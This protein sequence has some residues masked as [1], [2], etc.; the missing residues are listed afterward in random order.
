MDRAARSGTATA[1]RWPVWI[2]PVGFGVA[3]AVTALLVT[4]AGVVAGLA[5]TE[6]PGDE[7]SVTIVGTLLQD[8]AL[9]ASAVFLGSR[10]GRVRPQDFGLRP[11]SLAKSVRWT[12]VALLSFYA[13]SAV[14]GALVEPEA[15]QDII[16]ALGTERGTGYLLATALLVIL[17]APVA[18]ELFFRGFFYRSLRNRLPPLG[19][20]SVVGLVFGAIHYTDADTLVLIPVLVLLGVIFCLLYERTG[21]L[22]PAIAMHAVNNTL[23]LA[24]STEASNAVPVSV[25]FGAVGLAA[26]MA[27]PA[28][29]LRRPRAGARA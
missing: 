18:E 19:A 8:F 22:Y 23:A 24:T 7:P 2:G 4:I 10:Y 25:A 16:D 15:E 17:V 5:G 14:Y 26:C 3:I 1:D 9:I 21:S 13:I 12:A 28:I 20:A 27:V 6:A 11:S 29:Q